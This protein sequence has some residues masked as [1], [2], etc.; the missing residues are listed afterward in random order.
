[1]VFRDIHSVSA[2]MVIGDQFA[3]CKV[4]L[5]FAVTRWL[6][7]F[8][9]DLLTNSMASPDPSAQASSGSS[10]CMTSPSSSSANLRIL[11]ENLS[12]TTLGNIEHRLP[13]AHEC[14]VCLN[15]L[16]KNSQVWELSN[17]SHVFHK[18]CLEKW[19]SYDSRMTCPLCRQ[20]LISPSS[21]APGSHLQQPSWAVERMLYLFGDDM[22]P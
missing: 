2:S 8:A 6:L 11:R 3:L 15:K 10:C 21:T 20:A 4:A 5:V 22:L 19:L 12:L 1:M 17:C 16:K 13:E 9:L 18:H 7:S 14:A